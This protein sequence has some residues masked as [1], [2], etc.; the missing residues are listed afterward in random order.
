M[1]TITVLTGILTVLVLAFGG[2]NAT[3]TGDESV[4]VHSSKYGQIL[5][6]GRGFALYSFTHDPNGKTTCTGA[7]AKAWPPYVVHGTVRAVAGAKSSL[8]GAV[9][10]ADGTMQ[11]TYAARPL[12][13]YVGDTKA[14]QVLCQNASAFGGTWLVLRATGRPVR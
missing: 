12:Y 9:R 4:A 1:R 11:V 13:Y 7:C 6:D 14:G 3:A 5:F 10:R 8:L 2:T